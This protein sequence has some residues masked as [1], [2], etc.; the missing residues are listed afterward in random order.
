MSITFKFASDPSETLVPFRKIFLD[1]IATDLSRSIFVNGSPSSKIISPLI[2]DSVMLFPVIFIL[3][4]RTF[5]PSKILNFISIFSPCRISSTL[6]S[7]N[8]RL[9]FDIIRS[10][11]SIS[12][13]TVNGNNTHQYISDILIVN[14]KI[15]YYQK[16]DQH[17]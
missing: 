4:T 14:Q 1:L 10:I 6:C 8:W 17:W 16:L 5:S 15:F 12:F 11:S 7:T 9:F 2:T 13:L 3:S